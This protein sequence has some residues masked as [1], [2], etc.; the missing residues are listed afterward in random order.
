MNELVIE[1]Q[2]EAETAAFGAKLATALRAGDVVR[3]E[4]PLGAGKSTLAR[5]LIRA[6]SG[7]RDVPSP[8]FTLVETYETDDAAIWHFDLF[9]LEDR[10]EVWELGLEDALETGVALIEWPQ[11]IEGMLPNE[12]LRLVLSVKEGNVR[13]LHIIAPERW[14]PALREAGI[15]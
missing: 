11:R 15:A 13:Q 9:R 6:A 3:L 5:G 1:F 7:A 14:T 12:A 2:N 4:G 8:T 10:D